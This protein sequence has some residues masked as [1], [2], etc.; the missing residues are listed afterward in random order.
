[1]LFKL[2][3]NKIFVFIFLNYKIENN[4]IQLTNESYVSTFCSNFPANRIL[5][6][7]FF[8]IDPVLSKKLSSS[9]S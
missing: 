8:S 5:C 4:A 1:M 3:Y 6:S 2:Q 9:E 7:R